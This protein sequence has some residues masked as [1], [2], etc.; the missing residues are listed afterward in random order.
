MINGSA[1]TDGGWIH[2]INQ[3]TRIQNRMQQVQE[4]ES[5]LS[6]H[7]QMG[8]EARL[9]HRYDAVFHRAMFERAEAQFLESAR[10]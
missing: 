1:F 7:Q 2:D 8:L 3:L 4:N 6:H 5:G 10:G 9:A